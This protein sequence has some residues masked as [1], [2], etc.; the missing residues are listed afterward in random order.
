MADFTDG[1]FT[2]VKKMVTTAY[3]RYAWLEGCC[4]KPWAV[5]LRR[6]PERGCNYACSFQDVVLIKPMYRKEK[7]EFVEN[8]GVSL[9]PILED[10]PLT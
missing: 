4:V 10:Y 6:V 1:G 7:I 9:L 8:S 5:L 2:Q 3:S